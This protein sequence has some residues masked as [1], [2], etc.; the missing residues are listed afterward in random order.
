MNAG[1][2]PV[3]AAKGKVVVAMSGGVDSAVAAFLLK[4]E[5]YDV[6]AIT[7]CLA[8]AAGE[9]DRAKCCGPR[10]IED[11]RRVC[12]GLGIPH[13]VMDFSGD[14]EEKVI[15][16]FVMEYLRGRTP[17][18]CIECNRHLKFGTLLGKILA[19]GFDYLATGHYCSLIRKNGRMVMKIPRDGKKD[20]TYFLYGIP[21]EALPHLLFPLADLAKADVRALAFRKS[22][23]ARISVS[24]PG[25]IPG[26]S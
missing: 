2:G 22:G 15:R 1:G 6:T 9:G 18:P 12:R 19:M 25:G 23:K 16:P 14:L 3:N 26:L 7:M 17:N 4:E 13:F 10:E 21:R 11:A 24:S 5:G 20:Q 8:V